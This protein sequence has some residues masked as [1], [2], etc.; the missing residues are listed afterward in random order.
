MKPKK[1]PIMTVLKT[2]Y[3]LTKYVYIKKILRDK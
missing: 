3:F 1:C 2:F